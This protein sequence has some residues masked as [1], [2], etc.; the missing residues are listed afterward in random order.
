M[1]GHY[2]I[3]LV[4]SLAPTVLVCI[5]RRVLK[6]LL[7]FLCLGLS[8]CGMIPNMAPSTNSSAAADPNAPPSTTTTAVSSTANAAAAVGTAVAAPTP[9]NI[10]NAVDAVGNA[11]NAVNAA[12]STT[13]SPSPGSKSVT[14]DTVRKLE[15]VDV[16]VDMSNPTGQQ[17]LVPYLMKPKDWMLVGCEM[18][19]LTSKHYRFMKVSTNDGKELPSVDI[20]SPR[21]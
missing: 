17:A 6:H 21:R 16:Y 5:M 7:P 15:Y 10:A 4:N 18:T 9:T 8:A 2:P 11:A 12:T 14:F 13:G 19:S 20:F 1:R 3:F